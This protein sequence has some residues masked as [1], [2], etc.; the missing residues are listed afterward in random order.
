MLADRRPPNPLTAAY[1]T[2]GLSLGAAV[3]PI[4]PRVAGL[5]DAATGDPRVVLVED[6]PGP[7]PLVPGTWMKLP[8]DHD[9]DYDWGRDNP[10]ARLLAFELLAELLGVEPARS[11]RRRFLR[12]HVIRW[13]RDRWA[14]QTIDLMDWALGLGGPSS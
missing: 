5:R 3:R 14:M 4:P 13:P 10:G 1:P 12:E 7:R 11:L 2:D 9:H 6:G 8:A